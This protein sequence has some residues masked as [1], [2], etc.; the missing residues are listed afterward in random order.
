MAVLAQDRP[1]VSSRTRDL[2]PHFM[3]GTVVITSLVIVAHLAVVLWLSFVGGSPT[4]ERL[5]YGLSN[6]H[7]VFTGTR[8]YRVV[9]DT[10]GFGLYSLAVALLFG[11]P[12]AWLAERTTLPGKTVLFTLMTLGILIPDFAS[13]MGWLFLLHPRIGIVNVFLA[14][15]F[16]IAGPVFDVTGIAG[17]GWVQGLNLAPLAFI[18]TAAVFRSLDPSLEEAAQMSGAGALSSLRRI[19]APLA[20]PGILAAVIYIFTISFAAFDVPA[21]I[22]WS[23]RTYTFSTYLY[24][25]IN[26]QDVNPHYGLAAALSSGMMIFAGVLSVWYGAMQKRSRRF[27]VVTGK[28]Y[29][30]RLI[31]IGR[32]AILAWCFIG[33]YFVLSK[34]VPLVLLAWASFLPYFQLPSARAIAALS[35][36]HYRALPW[37]LAITGFSNTALLAILTPAITLAIAIAFSW[38]VLRSRLRFRNLFDLAAF[39]PHAIPGNV[40]GIGALLIALYALQR[41]IPIYGTI[42][43]L[44]LV[45]VIA[46]LSYATRMTNAGL[47]QIHTELE[48]SAQVGGATLAIIFRRVLLPLLAPTLLYAFLWIALLTFRE[49]TLAVF[50]STSGNLTLPVLIWSLWLAG[51]LGQAS[52]LAIIMLTLMIPITGLYWYIARRQQQILD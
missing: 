48:E 37:N 8:T 29:R 17:M 42:W 20:W 43:I 44:L 26:P 39:L 13:S 46:R 5:I 23:S 6:Y 34:L 2:L 12:T 11:I 40:F 35:L 52:A 15:T 16:G 32:K 27:A 38:V 28:A 31:P 3:L 30:P 18:M 47:I 7:E 1:D 51:G 22:G 49:L 9:L 36:V 50:L 14:Q 33:L 24:L 41:L 19:T 25:L 21:I 10:C 45:F 4:D